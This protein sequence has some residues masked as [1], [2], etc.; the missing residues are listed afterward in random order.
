MDSYGA[1]AEYIGPTSIAYQFHCQLPNQRSA[2]W[3]NLLI[4]K[5]NAHSSAL[6]MADVYYMAA[7]ESS[8][9]NGH[10]KARKYQKKGWESN[11]HP[12]VNT[13]DF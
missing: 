12:P 3:V 9:G 1:I 7:H 13:L 11:E 2:K 4:S 8:K 10:M 6:R 5:C